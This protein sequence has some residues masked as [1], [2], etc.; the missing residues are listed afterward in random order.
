MGTNIVVFRGTGDGK[1]GERWEREREGERKGG[2]TDGQE[3]GGRYN[4]LLQP[5]DRQ[6]ADKY[7]GESYREG[8]IHAIAVLTY[9]LHETI[10]L[11]THSLGFSG[12]EYRCIC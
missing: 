1:G 4:A 3:G 11:S 10:A 12:I 7:I 2:D 9:A 6:A 5:R 8:R